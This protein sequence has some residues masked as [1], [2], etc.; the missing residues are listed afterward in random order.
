MHTLIATG[1]NAEGYRELLG[2]QVTLAEDEAG[3]LT[4]FATPSTRP[5]GG[6]GRVPATPAPGWSPLS[7]PPCPRLPR[8]R[9]RTHYPANLKSFTPKSSWPWPR[10]LLRSIYDQPASNLLSADMVGY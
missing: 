4:S 6:S 8:Q 2:L 9:C 7:G 3:W 10:T 1:V 5:V